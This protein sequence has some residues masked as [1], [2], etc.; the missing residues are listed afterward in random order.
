MR[1]HLFYSSYLVP[2]P[3]NMVDMPLASNPLDKE[4]KMQEWEE[5][6]KGIKCQYVI[7]NMQEMCIDKYILSDKYY[8]SY[9]EAVADNNEIEGLFRVWCKFENPDFIKRDKRSRSVMRLA[10][11]K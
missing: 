7:K 2:R 1:Y 5:I 9:E 11:S 6:H 3:S 8:E 4:D 10:T